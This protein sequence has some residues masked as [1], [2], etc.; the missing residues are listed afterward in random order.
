MPKKT[1]KTTNKP[2]VKFNEFSFNMAVD[3]M[4]SMVEIL[5]FSKEI[6]EKMAQNCAIDG[7]ADGHKM[8]MARS[9]IAYSLYEKFKH[10]AEIGEPIS[11]EIH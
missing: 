7:N 3:E 10:V 1:Q 6:F 5:G 4:L 2:P 9:Q 11:R 8:F